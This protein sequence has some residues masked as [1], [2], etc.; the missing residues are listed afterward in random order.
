MKRWGWPFCAT[1]GHP[2]LFPALLPNGQFNQR[3][4]ELGGIIEQIRQCV[5]QAGGL[6]DPDDPVRLIDSAPLPVCTYMRAS[7]NTTLAGSEYFSVMTTRKAKLFGL[8]LHLT[9]TPAQVVD[10]WL[11]APAAPSDGKVMAGFLEDAQDLIVFGDGAYHD[12]TVTQ[13]LRDRHNIQV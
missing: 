11:L 10:H 3:R 1:C 7:R 13:W 5:L 9:V 4:R 2:E 6:I 8:R 12:P